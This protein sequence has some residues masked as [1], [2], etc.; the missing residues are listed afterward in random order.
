M[1]LM[2]YVKWSGKS[3]SIISPAAE[4]AGHNSHDDH[5]SNEN[6]DVNTDHYI[7]RIYINGSS[8]ANSWSYSVF[9]SIPNNSSPSVTNNA[10]GSNALVL[11]LLMI[12]LWYIIITGTSA[13]SW[14]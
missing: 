11:L 9:N 1:R 3:V 13:I 10:N 8:K 14:Y 6:V 7:A 12:W 2:M 4:T 5:G